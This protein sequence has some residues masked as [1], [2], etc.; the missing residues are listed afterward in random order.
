MNKSEYRLPKLNDPLCDA[1]LNS[2]TFTYKIQE[3]LNKLENQL[4]F[5]HDPSDNNSDEKNEP[6]LNKEKPFILKF[7]EHQN[8]LCRN[9]NNNKNVRNTAPHKRIEKYTVEK[10]KLPIVECMQ[11]SLTNVPKTKTAKEISLNDEISQNNSEKLDGR[12]SE[13]DS[14]NNLKTFTESVRITFGDAYINECV[15]T[16]SYLNKK[17][18]KQEEKVLSTHQGE[19][20]INPQ[21]RTSQNNKSNRIDDIVDSEYREGKPPGCLNTTKMCCH[22]GTREPTDPWFS[23][24][25]L[26]MR[27]TGSKPKLSTT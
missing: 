18:M 5:K 10:K 9:H 15:K 7:I 4:N 2:L 20:N 22:L 6:I 21:K 23:L 12:P 16:V 19:L 11:C 27:D 24:D 14:A 25:H 8:R 13:K 26:V 17:P 3:N 1:N